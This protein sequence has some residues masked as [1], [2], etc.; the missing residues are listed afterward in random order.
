[1]VIRLLRTYRNEGTNGELWINNEQVC[2]TIELS[3]LD[4][5]RNK[6]CIPEGNYPLVKRYSQKFGWH[7]WIKEVVG[8]S[9]ILLHVGNDAKRDLR[10]C[11]A[12]VSQL[13]G[14]GKGLES[15]K[16]FE[17]VKSLIYA[18]IDRREEVVLEVVKKEKL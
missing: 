9:L 13:A 11:I 14:E 4:N 7:I 15:R 18:S 12:P 10:G 6:S 1:M 3:W 2:Y 16:A 17:R 8:R 5:V